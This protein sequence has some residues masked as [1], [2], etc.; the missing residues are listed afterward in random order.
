MRSLRLPVLLLLTLTAPLLAKEDLT[1][2]DCAPDELV[3]Q[4]CAPAGGIGAQP[5]FR[6]VR[7]MPRPC[8][9]RKR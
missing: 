3:D 8:D 4:G 2:D 1:D 7:Q 9:A 6:R 5:G